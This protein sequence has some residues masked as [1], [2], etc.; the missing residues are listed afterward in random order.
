MKDTPRFVITHRR[1]ACD[2]FK[3]GVV[4]DMP[5][6]ALIGFI[7]RVQSDMMFRSSDR[8]EEQ[9]LVI[10]YDT[11]A[12]EFSWCVHPD[13]PVDLLMG[14]LEVAKTTLVNVQ[15]SQMEAGR[16]TGIIRG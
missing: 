6:L 4:G 8:C 5:V 1:D 10:S 9:A 11:E 13:I 15:L 14:I 16:R 12:A 3:W 7:V 2:Q